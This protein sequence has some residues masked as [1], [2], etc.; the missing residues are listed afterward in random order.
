MGYFQNKWNKKF[1]T[2]VVVIA[3]PQEIWKLYFD[4][5]LI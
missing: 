1:L 5:T 3:G 2:P 4:G